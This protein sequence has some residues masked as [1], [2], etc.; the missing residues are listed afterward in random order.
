MLVRMC[1]SVCAP[2]TGRP[3]E[4]NCFLQRIRGLLARACA[5]FFKRNP[6]FGLLVNPS[7]C[8]WM[9]HGNSLKRLPCAKHPPSKTRSSARER[10][11]SEVVYAED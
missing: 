9:K 2:G 8:F 4:Q 5:A 7:K 6:A 3:E 10:L 11:P 1:V